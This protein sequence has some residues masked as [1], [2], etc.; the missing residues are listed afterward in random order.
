MKKNRILLLISLMALMMPQTMKAEWTEWAIHKK[1]NNPQIKM[2]STPEEIVNIL[3]K[4]DGYEGYSQVE[5]FEL[6]LQKK[7][8]D[9]FGNVHIAY[10]QKDKNKEDFT[11]QQLIL[12]FRPDGSLYYR[13]GTLFIEKNDEQTTRAAKA[14][15][16]SAESAATIATGSPMSETVL[17]MTEHL[18][19]IHKTYRVKDN[20]SMSHVYVDAYSGEVLF[21]IPLIHSYESWDKVKGTTVTLPATTGYYG[22][23]DVTVMQTDKGYVLRDPTRNIITVEGSNGTYSAAG[24][25]SS[26]NLQKLRISELSNDFL[27]ADKEELLD[28]KCDI[29]FKGL[30]LKLDRREERFPES[31][32]IHLYTIDKEGKPLQDIFNKN[33]D[34]ITWESDPTNDKLSTITFDKPIAAKLLHQEHMLEVTLYDKVYSGKNA[35]VMES[36]DTR[37][38]KSNTDGEWLMF[39]Q[40]LLDYDVYPI[41][42]AM[43]VHWGVQKTY[44]MYYEYYGI[45][46]NDG[47][48]TQIINVINPSPSFSLANGLPDNA[49]AVTEAFEDCTGTTTYAML[50]GLGRPNTS[51][52]YTCIDLM[53]HE[54]SHLV[55]Q[56]YGY[57]MIYRNESGA[58][59]ESL[60]DCMAMITEDYAL[61]KPTWLMGEDMALEFDY[62]RNLSD[63]WLSKSIDGKIDP[64]QAQAKYYQGLYWFDY[65][66]YG[67]NDPTTDSGGVHTN[68][69]VFNYLFYLLCEGGNNLTNEKEETRDIIPVGMEKMKDI[70]FHSIEYYNAGLCTYAEIADNLMI[71]VEDIYGDDSETVA[72]LQKKFL[73]AYEFVGLKSTDPTGITRYQM[74]TETPDSRSY[75]LHGIPV[76][77][78]Y[79]GIII[80]NGKKA[81]RN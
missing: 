75:N 46:G 47:K 21:S 49:V 48:G 2:D 5:G 74:E 33:I 19:K 69:G 59:N 25:L 27:I 70:V 16:I 55:T 78:D 51:K 80:K 64:D 73:S 28:P 44:D 43:D 62:Y 4:A 79:K 54:Y 53:A 56:A 68:N 38:L 81:I 29:L 12:H 13:N 17:T 58:L 6:V 67:A 52:P 42:Q 37:F 57:K 26:A 50:Y 10:H 63:P 30:K 35:V 61:G 15:M 20:K 7:D 40:L 71:T 9:K 8:T 72:D 24:G 3:L 45:K 39:K 34:N 31:F 77:D 36:H 76:R 41:K 22:V 65:T 14:S 32:N 18:N 23:Q 11:H 60:A 66:Q 1:D